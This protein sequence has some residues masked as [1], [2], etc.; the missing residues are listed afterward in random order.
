MRELRAA[1]R[2]ACA[3]HC[4]ICVPDPVQTSLPR[5][6]SRLRTHARPS[7]P[8]A[9][10]MKVHVC[11]VHDGRARN[12]M[13]PS[14]PE[15]ARCIGTCI[16]HEVESESCSTRCA[17][18]MVGSGSDHTT[19][20]AGVGGRRGDQDQRC[21]QGSAAVLP[22]GVTSHYPVAGRAMDIVSG[23]WEGW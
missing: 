3:P 17:H 4:A 8:G 22:P 18:D 11:C 5:V 10:A 19:L 14:A 6:L 2:A 7:L 20:T 13:L 9:A 1:L 23:L 16:F 21:R 15:L 12:N